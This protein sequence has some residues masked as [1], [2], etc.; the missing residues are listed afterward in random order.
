MAELIVQKFGGTSVANLECLR[1]VMRIVI[2][3]RRQG[4]DVVVVLSA[5]S[6]ETDRLINLAK[7][8]VNEPDAREYD[9]LVSIGEQCSIA[10]LSMMLLDQGYPAKSMTGAQAGII[11]DEIHKKA[12]IEEIQTEVIWQ[13]LRSGR[14]PVIAGFQ[15]I[16]PEGDISTLGRGG[17]DTTAVAIAAAMQAKECQIFTDVDGVYTSDPRVV[18]QA[19]RMASITLEEMLEMAS[20][21]AKVLQNRSVIFAGKYKVPLRVLSS[22][23]PGPGTLITYE[24]ITMEKPLVSGIAFNRSEAR[25]TLFGVPATA[26]VPSQ[27]LGPLAEANIDIDMILQNSGE[28][29][30]V[31]FTFTVN[32]EDYQQATNILERIAQKLSAKEVTGDNKI[33]KVSIIGVG[34]RSHA[35]VANTVFS[36][37]AQ[38]GIAVHLITT[39]E[40]KIS[41]VVDEKYLELAAR[42]LHTVFGLDN[43][44][45]EE[46]DPVS[47]LI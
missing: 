42:S 37:L 47:T 22:F 18:P 9:A 23:T 45:R 38:E 17:S 14:I 15:G 13:E 4:Y 5:M 20:L 32:R 1:N 19:R 3:T 12:H 28:G 36:T 11:T 26:N 40:I 6:G 35:G 43:E 46:F 31:N 34:M 7:T 8:A 10:L 30:T 16:T 21:G 24:D 44:L 2:E 25:L 41:V 33:A 39:S 27:I 29:N